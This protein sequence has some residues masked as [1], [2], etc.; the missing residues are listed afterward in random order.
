MLRKS[1]ARSRSGLL[2]ALAI[3]ALLGFLSAGRPAREAAIYSGSEAER[4]SACATAKAWLRSTGDGA[5]ETGAEGSDAL[6]D[7]LESRGRCLGGQGRYSEAQI[8][9]ER[10]LTIRERLHGPEQ[11]SVATTLNALGWLHVSS[12]RH[13]DADASYRKALSIRTRILGPKHLDVARTCTD[14]A[15]LRL[16]QQ[17]FD[18]AEELA[19]M[20]LRIRER[21]LGPWHVAVAESVNLI[22]M[23]DQ[24]RGRRLEARIE[25]ERA[26]AIHGTLAEQALAAYL[27]FAVDYRLLHKL[28][29]LAPEHPDK[30]SILSN[31]ASVQVEEGRLTEAQESLEQAVEVF[32]KSLG[33]RHYYTGKALNNLGSVYQSQG[34]LRL[35]ERAYD[36]A[37]EILERSLPFEQ[38]GLALAFQNLGALQT[39]EERFAEAQSNLERAIAILS[40]TLDPGHP[41]LVK[42]RRNLQAC[43]EAQSR[44]ADATTD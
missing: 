18:E 35:A 26:L 29:W 17:R 33:P 9:L 19:V 22:G 15:S 13:M 42:A 41:H 10:S 11:A 6:A 20:A 8:L 2:G 14:L 43:R 12:G 5:R 44:L 7:A 31:L 23:I 4:R 38:H 32:G 37:I 3:P 36:G 21:A 28:R 39:G 16:L 24:S 27:P 34:K 1:G 25:F 40:Q 30:G